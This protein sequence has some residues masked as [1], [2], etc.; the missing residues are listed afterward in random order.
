LLVVSWDEDDLM[1][2]NR[3]PTIFFGAHVRVGKYAQ[4]INH[5][6]VLRVM[7]ESSSVDAGGECDG[8]ED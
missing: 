1:G 7:E 2:N 4:R 5:F 8:G 6:S 3:I